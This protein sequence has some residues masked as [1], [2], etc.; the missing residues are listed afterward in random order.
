MPGHRQNAA[1]N[2]RALERSSPQPMEPME[3]METM[4][5]MERI[6][7]QRKEWNLKI[8]KSSSS[9]SSWFFSFRITFA[10]L[11]MP[12]WSPSLSTLRPGRT[13]RNPFWKAVIVTLISAH[14]CT[15]DYSIYLFI[16]AFI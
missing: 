3:T 9:S 12:P 10:A 11:A 5:P 7:K 15:Y 13:W 2:S 1:E 6:A 16:Y 14:P 8:W 4:E